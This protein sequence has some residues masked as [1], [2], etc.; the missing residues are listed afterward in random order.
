MERT[1]DVQ[2]DPSFDLGRVGCAHQAF[3]LTRRGSDEE[4]VVG[5]G[6]LVGIDRGLCPPWLR[7]HAVWI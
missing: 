6:T 1:D 5:F 7:A 3:G 4:V 2:P